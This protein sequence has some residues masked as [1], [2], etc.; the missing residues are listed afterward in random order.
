MGTTQGFNLAISF[1]DSP[2]TTSSTVYKLAMR[3]N[4]GGTGYI[5]RRTTDNSFGG[6]STITLMEVAG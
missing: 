3:Q 2:A 6:V 1:L 5:N 4:S